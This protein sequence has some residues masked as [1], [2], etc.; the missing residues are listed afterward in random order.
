MLTERTPR[1][2]AVKRHAVGNRVKVITHG[3]YTDVF[4]GRQKAA[5]LVQFAAVAAFS[6]VHF[7]RNARRPSK[8]FRKVPNA[9]FSGLS[10]VV[11][12]NSSVE[13]SLRVSRATSSAI[14]SRYCLMTGWM[15]L[16]SSDFSAIS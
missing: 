15:A 11:L 8:K 10:A 16:Q 2:K 14:R 7:S 3:Q 6:D 13:K 5:L 1:T 9:G 4:C 12:R